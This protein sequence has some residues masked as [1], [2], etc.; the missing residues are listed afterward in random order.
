VT[1]FERDPLLAGIR[2]DDRFTALIVATKA[3]CDRYAALYH[4]LRPRMT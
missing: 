4:D 1:A 2:S 3:E